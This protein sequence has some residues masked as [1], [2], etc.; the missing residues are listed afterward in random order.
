MKLSEI[1]SNEHVLAPWSDFIGKP[2]KLPCIYD[3]KNIDIGLLSKVSPQTVVI[4]NTKT[5][6]I[7]GRRT[8]FLKDPNSQK[9]QSPYNDP[10]YS[11]ISK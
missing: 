5:H 7:V 8:I 3:K 1:L 10:K 11:S 6:Q 9:V 4:K 2:I